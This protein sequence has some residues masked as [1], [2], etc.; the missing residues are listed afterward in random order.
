MTP[1]PTSR[2]QWLAAGSPPEVERTYTW[3]RTRHRMQPHGGPDLRRRKDREAS[4]EASTHL[5]ENGRTRES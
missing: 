5:D 3:G 4:Y 2:L 1:P